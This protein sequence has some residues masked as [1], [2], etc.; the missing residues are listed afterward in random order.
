MKNLLTISDCLLRLATLWPLAT[1][2]MGLAFFGGSI[3]PIPL[4]LAVMVVLALALLSF[5]PRRYMHA[6]WLW[7]SV[8]VIALYSA[9]EIVSA[10][11]AS[12]EPAQSVFVDLLFAALWTV[13]F[14]AQK[15]NRS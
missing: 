9:Y 11:A 15:R 12:S 2:F 7:L 10:V 3:G 4:L 13:F 6:K 8:A 14:V 1:E 5:A